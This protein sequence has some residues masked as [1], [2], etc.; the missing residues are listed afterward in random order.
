MGRS[1]TASAAPVIKRTIQIVTLIVNL[2]IIKTAGAAEV[3]TCVAITSLVDA[4]DQTIASVK[5]MTPADAATTNNHLK[6]NSRTTCLIMVM[7]VHF[8]T[9]WATS[10]HSHSNK[11]MT[12]SRGAQTETDRAANSLTRERGACTHLYR[13][14]QHRE[15]IRI[16][17]VGMAPATVALRR[18]NLRDWAVNL[19]S[20]EAETC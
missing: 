16:E 2:T 7:N 1:R 11:I 9:S 12:A 6:S 5:A 13:R 17:G 10:T 8:R 4:T 14:L 3:T 15:V 19:T 18:P 20:S